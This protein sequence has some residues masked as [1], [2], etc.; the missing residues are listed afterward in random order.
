MR[1]NWLAPCRIPVTLLLAIAAVDGGY[2]LGRSL[3]GPRRGLDFAQ[4]YVAARCVITGQPETMYDT[5]ALYQSQAAASGVVGLRTADGG[6]LE[7]MTYA[8]PPLLAYLAAPLALLT[9]RLAGYVFSFLSLAALAAAILLLFA[10]REPDRR[11]TMVLAGIAAASVFAPVHQTLHLGQ[12]NC[13][14]FL[15]CALGLYF[16]RRSSA[17]PAGLFIAIA[18]SIKLFPLVLLPFFAVRRQFRLLGT[19]LLFV[20]VLTGA[21]AAFGG[22]EMYRLYFSSVLPRQ[23]F[24][25]A[26]F[27]N[28]GFEG[29]FTRLFTHNDYVHSLGDYPGAAHV[30]ALVAGLT[31]LASTYLVTWKHS[32]KEP[33]SYDL[34]YGLCLAGA[35]LFQ[36]KSYE[37]HAVML[38]FLFLFLF[39]ALLYCGADRQRLL[40]V[41]CLSF[42]V[43]SFLLTSES[44]Y[45]KLPKLAIM[46][47]LF[48]AK[49]MAT[50]ALW[51]CGIYWIAVARQPVASGLP[52]T[53]AQTGP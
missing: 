13:V 41:V 47:V 46:N 8:Y 2:G 37:H 14:V 5:G 31:V 19:T 52:G 9:Y 30:A 21:T 12:V 18:V 1:N 3:F 29:F 20:G 25:G 22:T 36:A 50:L 7:V 16:A 49:F 11:R 15:C 38:L 28:Q 34:G 43:W 45:M 51:A 4:Y 17:W 44:E 40:A 23:Y 24:A 42:A 39:E 6:I 48:S 27:A 10:D 53:P 35:L 26:Y 32:S 33:S